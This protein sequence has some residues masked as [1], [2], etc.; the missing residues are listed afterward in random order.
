MFQIDTE[1]LRLRHLDAE[2]A[3][4]ILD[5]LNDAG[6]LRY[7]GD[8]GV[9][10]LDDARTYIAEGPVE[11]YRRH[12]FGLNHVG[13]RDASGASI[14]MCGLLKREHLPDPDIGF[15]LLPAHV[16]RGY[17]R[18]AAQ[19]VIAHAR[20]MLGVRRI[21]A[22]TAL[23]NAASIRLLEQLGFRFEGLVRSPGYEGD[24]RLFAW[25]A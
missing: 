6:F 15:A 13:L 12:G 25:S 2:D 10:S 22:T 19:A 16:S 14:G 3:P 7:I 18:E 1:R 9:R 20:D 5:L 24:S 21:L 4:M 11:S 17:A 8:R 23:D